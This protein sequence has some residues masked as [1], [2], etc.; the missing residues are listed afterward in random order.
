M[1]EGLR[2]DVLTQ[3]HSEEPERGRKPNV[4]RLPAPVAR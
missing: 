2:W 3:N 4:G 1:G